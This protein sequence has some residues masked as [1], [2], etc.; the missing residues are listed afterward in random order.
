MKN[1]L[2]IA[3]AAVILVVAAG[4]GWNYFKK[5]SE[6]SLAVS[7][8][9]V[10]VAIDNINNR[11]YVADNGS[12]KIDIYDLNTLTLSGSIMLNEPSDDALRLYIDENEGVALLNSKSNSQFKV[13][14]LSTKKIRCQ[15]EVGQ[16]SVGWIDARNKQFFQAAAAQFNLYDYNCQQKKSIAKDGTILSKISEAGE[17]GVLREKDSRLSIMDLVSGNIIDSFYLY[18]NNFTLLPQHNMLLSNDWLVVNF[19]RGTTTDVDFY[20]RSTKITSW[21]NTSGSTAAPSLKPVYLAGD[22]YFLGLEDNGEQEIIVVDLQ[23]KNVL[24][25]IAVSSD[26]VSYAVDSLGENIFILN[27]SGKI[28]K[29]QVAPVDGPAATTITKPLNFGVM[30]HLEG[31]L[32]FPN[33]TEYLRVNSNLKQIIDLFKKYNAKITI[34]SETPY[35]EAA[36]K[37]GDNLLLYA[38]ENGQGVGTHCDF[39]SMSQSEAAAA[40]KKRKDAID[41]AVGA[42]N[43]LGCSGGWGTHDWAQAAFSAGFSYLDAPIMIAYLAVPEENRPINPD[44]GKHYT[45]AEISPQ[46]KL[47]YHDVIP[48]ELSDRIYPR[49]LKDTNDLTGDNSGIVLIPGSLGEIPAL[50]EG[51]STCYP[52]CELTNKD[53]DYIFNAID[54]VNGF[55]DDSKVSS[56]YL[57]FPID[58]IVMPSSKKEENLKIVED[59]LKRMQ[60]YQTQGKI[61]WMTMKEIYE[62]YSGTKTSIKSWTPKPSQTPSLRPSPSQ[63]PSV[64][65]KCGDGVCGPIEKANPALC[66]QDCK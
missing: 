64:Q 1:K 11:L 33:K 59:W 45:D 41:A 39:D 4:L 22:L 62:E 63:S 24:D 27:K 47:Y 26:T 54:Q 55:K 40:Y 10:N 32:S 34:E 13:L 43:N 53:I 25:K 66:P 21:F 18:S 46:S 48:Y 5:S 16:D 30:L 17:I 28:E 57:H 65:G 52:S 12:N 19:N 38:L 61:K 3:L 42:E 44:T 14:D 7:Y 23:N 56:L 29:K 15:I 36:N 35:I 50:Y 9:N 8:T 31:Q 6:P 20:D 58:T 2:L 51:R 37:W 49:R 60:E